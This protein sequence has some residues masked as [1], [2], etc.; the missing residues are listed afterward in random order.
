MSS[1]SLTEPTNEA[2]ADI[3]EEL[4]ADAE[5][6]PTKKSW[7]SSSGSARDGS[8][9]GRP[10]GHSPI[11]SRSPTPRS[12]TTT[13]RRTRA[14]AGSTCSAPT[15]ST[16]NP[17]PVDLRGP[18][19]ADRRLRRRVLGADHR[20]VPAM[21]SAYRRGRIDTI[22]N[23]GSYILLAFPAIVAVIAIVSF[24]SHQL[25]KIT[26]I[27]GVF[28]APLIYRI[29]RAATL[30]YATR[31]FVLAARHSGRATPASW[32]GDPAQHHADHPLVR[33]D[34]RGDDHRVGGHVGLPRALGPTAHAELGQHAL[35][36]LAAPGRGQ[37]PDQRLARHLPGQ[38]DVPVADLPEHLWPTGCGHTST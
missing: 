20:G 18:R 34:R 33:P 7:A 36:G 5:A 25:W 10:R 11:S 21:L 26:L 6:N 9:G 8:G 29:V 1:V 35:R 14:R 28:G 37:G 4:V 32:A 22:L 17:Q 13:G 23:T 30:S 27:V 24:W 16:A 38:C 3:K 31:D 12:G 2:F 15:T 19:L